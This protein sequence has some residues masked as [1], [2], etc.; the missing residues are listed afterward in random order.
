MFLQAADTAQAVP[1][2]SFFP[3]PVPQRIHPSAGV[4]LPVVPETYSATFLLPDGKVFPVK[5][6]P[7]HRA[8]NSAGTQPRSARQFSDLLLC[9]QL[10]QNHRPPDN[11][12]HSFFLNAQHAKGFASSRPISDSS[13]I[14]VLPHLLFPPVR[15]DGK[16]RYN[17]CALPQKSHDSA[18]VST[19]IC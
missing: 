9:C 4:P 12:D 14:Q 17:C 5:Y 8:D 6:V 7:S 10:R 3:L 18:P 13:E 16:C 1:A 11:P 15:S 2:D 19:D